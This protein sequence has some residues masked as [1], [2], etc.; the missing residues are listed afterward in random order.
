MTKLKL[1]TLLCL[2]DRQPGQQAL[3]TLGMLLLGLGMSVV[4]QEALGLEQVL[5]SRRQMLPAFWHR[6]FRAVSQVH[7]QSAQRAH[8]QIVHSICDVM[9]WVAA[10][11][12]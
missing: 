11:A 4:R 5:G 6:L 9:H 7:T 8:P 3:H 1:L 12:G 2:G 10:A